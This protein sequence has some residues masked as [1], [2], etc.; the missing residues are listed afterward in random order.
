MEEVKKISVNKMPKWFK[1]CM[2]AFPAF[3]IIVF[4]SGVDNDFYFLYPT[5]EYIV[6]HGF[7]VKDFLSMHTDMS[8]IV[9]QWLSA[10]IYYFAYNL[11]GKV[12]ALGVVC[13]CYFA[14][15]ILIYRF[16]MLISSNHLVSCLCATVADFFIASGFMTT[17]PQI[18]TYLIIVTELILLEKYT[19]TGKIAW[20]VPIP[21]MSVLQI[22]LH[23]AMW[24]ML[25]VFMMPY[26]AG[27]IKLNIP[28]LGIKQEPCCKL[29][30]ILVTAVITFAA[31][32]LNPYGIKA[33]LYITTSFGYDV[34]SDN[35]QEMIPPSFANDSGKWLI[36]GLALL[37]FVT[38]IY[39]KRKFTT[40]FAL[41]FA[42]TLA[43]GLMSQ[44]SLAYFHIA[45]IPAVAYMFSDIDLT[46]KFTKNTEKKDKRTR[47]I[48]I[49]LILII[50]VAGAAVVALRGPENLT[51]EDEKHATTYEELDEVCDILS[52]HEN[53]EIVLYGG[54]NVGQYLEFKGYHPFIDG[55]AELFLKDNN[56]VEDYL[57]EY[58][59][60]KTGK[61][62]YK[63]FI[64]KYDFNY[65][66]FQT[67]GEE[68]VINMLERDGDFEKVYDGEKIIMYCR[69][70]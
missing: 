42:G 43:L 34:I 68:P 33:M 22:N 44:K 19:R 28:K 29:I 37:A 35:I 15:M 40:R 70:G 45:G 63:D 32:F 49:S 5:G 31:G 36:A 1:L 9:Q 54:F 26:I 14:L 51:E 55:R 61:T 12:G 52:Q 13:I 24:A 58:R 17:R 18:F 65:L 69:E 8:I 27:A 23:A 25:F 60:F 30:P 4:I 47:L 64:D 46:L 57:T 7:P 39:K 11:L 16:A 62:Y 56:G 41:L 59:D 50:A 21:F 53:G 67:K 38:L 66:V 2:A 10:V 3:F 48:L 6:N 20:L